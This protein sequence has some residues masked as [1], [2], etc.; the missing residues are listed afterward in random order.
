[1]EAFEQSSDADLGAVAQCLR[2]VTVKLN[3][4]TANPAFNLVLHTAPNEECLNPP[5]HWHME[6]LPQITRAAGFEWG[7]G[8]HMNSVAPEDA[9]RLLREA[10]V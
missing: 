6:I 1:V 4:V 7:T 5:Y 10:P 8:V 9:A 3:A 2:A